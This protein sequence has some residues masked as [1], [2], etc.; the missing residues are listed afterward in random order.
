MNSLGF[1]KGWG[2][3]AKGKEKQDLARDRGEER[4]SLQFC[5]RRAKLQM[6]GVW[7]RYIHIP[8]G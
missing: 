3:G 8:A 7:V 5:F 2:G 4:L 1:V 6:S